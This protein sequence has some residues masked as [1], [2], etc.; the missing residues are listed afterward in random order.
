MG[1]KGNTPK[2][3]SKEGLGGP[4]FGGN[5][6]LAEAYDSMEQTSMV[7]TSTNARRLPGKK[8]FSSVWQVE[9]RL[10][11]GTFSD[12][13]THFMSGDDRSRFMTLNPGDFSEIA[14]C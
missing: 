6:G 5:R 11:C 10:P 14:F 1:V 7:D 2:H 4:F 8:K 3:R 13:S 9:H 12:L